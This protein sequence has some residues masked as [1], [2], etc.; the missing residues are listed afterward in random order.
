MKNFNFIVGNGAHADPPPGTLPKCLGDLPD[1]PFPSEPQE[2]GPQNTPP[3]SDP[4]VPPPMPY[5][6]TP[7][8]PGEL[9]L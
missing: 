2:S 4:P 6:E 7:R 3:D 5:P 9:Q 8:L 1:E